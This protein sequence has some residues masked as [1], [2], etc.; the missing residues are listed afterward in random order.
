MPEGAVDFERPGRTAGAVGK[1]WCTIE[2]GRLR[3][4]LCPRVCELSEGQR[5]FC[6]VRINRGGRMESTT[7]GSCCGLCID[8]VEK[9][10]LYHFLPGTPVLSLGTEGCN[11]TCRFCQN[12]HLSRSRGG[13]PVREAA[14]A[15]VA[16]AAR[17][18][19]CRSVAFTYNDPVVFAEYAVD[20]AKAC[21]DQGVRT[22]AVTNG[23]IAPGA[24]EWFFSH[25]DAANIDL[26]SFRDGFYQKLCGARLQPVL[27][28]LL[29]VHREAGTWLEITTLLIPG[30]NDSETELDEL[31]DWIA[32]ELGPEVPLHL[33]AFHPAYLHTSAPRTPLGTL[34]RARE[35]VL[36]RGLRHVYIGN[37]E[38]EE[39]STTRCGSCSASL[40]G[41][42]GYEIGHWAL[43]KGEC[44]SCGQ[45]LAGV[46]EDQ[47]GNWGNRRRPL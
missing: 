20:T 1:F 44:R 28:T 15:E 39:G 31:G 19:A 26:K 33:S 21:H 43:E 5:G 4:E 24:R 22:I 37:A 23:Y 11:L 8:P 47:P 3:C 17:E 18:G 45:R 13:T 14:P 41:R 34:R 30:E 16:L 40:I 6:A 32:R 12:S 42:S 27:D 2:D 7:Y 36:A 46:F 35:I 38:D 25:M 9:K 29:H 10:P